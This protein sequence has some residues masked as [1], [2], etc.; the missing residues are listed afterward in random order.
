MEDSVAAPAPEAIKPD[1]SSLK[2]MFEDSAS[3]TAIARKESQTDRDYF[4]GFQWTAE[5]RRVLNSR[6][7]P[8]NVF[9]RVR[10]AIE[11]V[12]GVIEQG[13]TDP[14][15]WPRNPDDEQSADVATKV[16]RYIEDESDFDGTKTE[17]ALDF[18]IEG[19]C[20]AIV[21]MDG[22]EVAVNQIRYEEFFYDPR[23]RRKDFKDAR[24]MGVAKWRYADEVIAEYP[25]AKSGID[26]ALGG[27]Q[28]GGA[29]FADR[30]NDASNS[31]SWV[32]GKKR[33]LMVVELY[34]LDA[35]EWQRCVFYSGDTL[36]FGPSP[37]QDGKG[38]A[39][40]PIE[41]ASCY[42]DRENNR[43]GK[44]R[45]MRGPQDEINK[46]RSKLLL[47]VSTS[48][49]QAVDPAAQEIDADAARKEAARPDGVIP[50]GWQKVPTTD[51]AAGQANLLAEAKGEIERM[52]PNPAILGRQGES[53]SGRAQLVRQQAGLTELA[54]ALGVFDRW[55][56]RIYQA[57][58]A[59]AKQFWKAPKFI[60]I[61]DDDGAPEFVGL[62]Q[63]GPAQVV[64]G[65]GGMP[66][67]QPGPMQNNIGEMMV[68]I[69]IETTPD[70]ANVAQE[71]FM[72]LVELAKAGVQIPPQIL[73]EASALPEK[74]KIVEK[75]QQL[76]EQPD[77]AKELQVAGAKADIENTQA[78]TNLKIVEAETK[79]VSGLIGAYQAGASVH[80]PAAGA[81]GASR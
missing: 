28:L 59:C 8:D 50:Y 39:R 5:E 44:V 58:W 10:P 54:P 61:T 36:A 51:M 2:K 63:A 48:Q 25:D 7:Q 16:L 56:L 40:C 80:Q 11:G 33:R 75:L 9:N 6:S 24:Y 13:Q 20:A 17:C 21:E 46:R 27:A 81:S 60:R 47:L 4:D 67:I 35:G 77:P 12:I 31:V 52:G 72:A 71:Q 49:I 79:H 37:Y 38:K 74:R 14:K 1:I 78:D 53:S 69:T 73:I 23:S 55:T 41:A 64:Q 19:T 65:P 66:M 42:I 76:S 26:G 68:D 62:N 43:Y 45:D 70:T 22:E 30:P 32:D 57:M 15:A 3:L 29:T 18:F 34:H